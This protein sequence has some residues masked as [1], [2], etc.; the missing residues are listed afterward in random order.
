MLARQRNYSPDSL[1]LAKFGTGEK[2]SF[3]FPLF[4]KPYK[5]TDINI[6]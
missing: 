6:Q 2:A 1:A 4:Y 5:I 3:D